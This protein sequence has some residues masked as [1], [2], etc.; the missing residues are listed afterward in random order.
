MKY[1]NL[2]LALIISNV[3]ATIENSEEVIHK[4]PLL[5]APK[6]LTDTEIEELS[7]NWQTSFEWRCGY[8]LNFECYYSRGKSSCILRFCNIPL[9]SYNFQYIENLKKLIENYKQNNN[10]SYY[11]ETPLKFANPNPQKI[12][13]ETLCNLIKDKNFIF[14]TGAGI[15]AS[16]VATMKALDNAIKIDKNFSA[17]LKEIFFSPQ[18]ISDA[19]K[20]FCKTAI[21]SE[22]TEAHYALHKIAQIKKVAILTENVDLLQQRTTSMPIF[23]HSDTLTNLKKQDFEEIDFIICVGLSHDDCGFIAHYKKQNPN[24]RIISIDLGVPNYLSESDFLIQEDIQQFLP[25]FQ[26]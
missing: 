9:R 14:Y 19:F 26:T 23:V 18:R 11:Y 16:K 20:E 7:N 13:L 12:D 1:I 2:F 15:S 17:F 24:G 4:N 5:Q 3:S 10:Y 25:R 21:Y 8:K 22:P 6:I